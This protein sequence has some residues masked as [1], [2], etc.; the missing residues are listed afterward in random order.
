M[1]F[2]ALAAAFALAL[3]GALAVAVPASAHPALTVTA[4][5]T[6]VVAGT[7][8]T[9]TVAGTSNG[10][11]TGARIDVFSTGGPGALTSFTTFGSCGGG[12]TCTEVGSLYR[13][14][15]PALTNGQAFSYTLTLTVDAATAATTFT[16]KAQFYT[17]G[18][19]TTGAA[20]GPV[21]TVTQPLPD[22]QATKI[23]VTY[24]A[25][26]QQI[27][28]QWNL[29]NIGTA[30]A[31][32]RT[33]TKTISPSGFLASG[34]GVGCT[35]GPDTE[36]CPGPNLAVGASINPTFGRTVSLLAL[37]NYT[38]TFTFNT[39]NDP[40]PANDTITFNCSVLTGLIVSCT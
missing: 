27:V 22:V 6:T 17:S 23:G 3:C 33:V 24:N 11:Y 10:N 9:I 29:R 18:G 34:A 20:T 2:R 4:A 37:G 28:F 8:T 12:V 35:G 40:N 7:A 31:T 26:T 39:P 16:P 15:L 19:S 32:G 36:T 21:I 1:K 30:T 14:A 5:P 13:M 38:A 25:L